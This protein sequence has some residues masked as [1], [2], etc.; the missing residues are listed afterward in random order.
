MPPVPIV[1]DVFDLWCGSRPPRLH[2]G[3]AKNMWFNKKHHAGGEIATMEEHVQELEDGQS[4]VGFL[5]NKK[6]N[7]KSNR[8]NSRVTELVI[9]ITYRYQLKIVQVYAPTTSHSDE[10]AAIRFLEHN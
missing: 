1:M 6:L 5:I 9:H 8:W 2:T 10:D 3:G 4:R 7:N